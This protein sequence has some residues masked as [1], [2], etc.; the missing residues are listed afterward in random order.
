[1]YKRQN[2]GSRN[3]KTPKD[4][5]EAA[6]DIVSNS[7]DKQKFSIR[8]TGVLDERLNNRA[9]RS[10]KKSLKQIDAQIQKSEDAERQKLSAEK[11]QNEEQRSRTNFLNKKR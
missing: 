11:Q 2:R 5:R 4:I 6:E 8:E 3:F 10:L 7:N 9:R 1:M